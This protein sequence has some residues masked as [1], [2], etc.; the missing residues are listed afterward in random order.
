MRVQSREKAHTVSSPRLPALVVQSPA[1]S[2]VALSP[3]KYSTGKLVIGP[4]S[5]QTLLR[6]VDHRLALGALV[7]LHGVPQTPLTE[8]G[9]SQKVDDKICF[10]ILQIHLALNCFLDAILVVSTGVE[11]EQVVTDRFLRI[12]DVNLTKARMFR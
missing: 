11:A 8:Q 9:V 4:V 12:P 1:G 6:A 3:P 2:D 10:L 5:V 7:C